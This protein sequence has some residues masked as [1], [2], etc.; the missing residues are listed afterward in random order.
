LHVDLKLEPLREVLETLV[1][2]SFKVYFNIVMR[3]VYTTEESWN[4]INNLY[5]QVYAKSVAIDFYNNGFGND[6]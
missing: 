3:V 4:N 6:C 2:T 1:L 5:F